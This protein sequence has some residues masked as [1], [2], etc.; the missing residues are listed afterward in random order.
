MG[1]ESEIVTLIKNS[2]FF[3]AG[4]DFLAIEK[5]AALKSISIWDINWRIRFCHALQTINKTIVIENVEQLLNTPFEKFMS[6]RNC[7][8]TTIIEAR[9]TI[10]NFLLSI[11][12]NTEHENY[13]VVLK[14]MNERR[15]FV[16]SY[17]LSE[18][19]NVSLDSLKKY[20]NISLQ[21]F[22][23]P[24]RF[25]NYI[26]RKRKASSFSDLLSLDPEVLI[27]EK[28]MGR[29]TIGEV[30]KIIDKKIER[31][32]KGV[33]QLEEKSVLVIVNQELSKISERELAIVKMRW[34][35]ENEISMEEIGSRFQLTRE[36]IRQIIQ[37]IADK[38]W[39]RLEGR[40]EYYRKTFL[41]YLVNQPAPITKQIFYD[42]SHDLLY[43]PR[44]YLGLLAEI[45]QEVPFQDFMP[46]AFYQLVSREIAKESSW[47]YVY[48]L[49]E[50][51]KIGRDKISTQKLKEILDA[52]KLSNFQQLLCFKI[53]F[54]LKKYFFLQEG[55]KYY[56]LRKGG[57]R[58]MTYM[59]LKNSEVPLSIEE[60]MALVHKYYYEGSKYDSL[61][62]VI[63]SIKQDERIIQ[64]DKYIFGVKNHFSYPTKEWKNICETVKDFLRKKT[65]QCYVTE[66]LENIGNKYPRLRSKYE[67]VCILRDD[68]EIK[69]LGFFNFTLTSYGQ[70][71]RI[72]VSDIIKDIFKKDPCV[73]HVFD[74]R[75]RLKENRFVHDQG[76]TSL[77]KSQK[78]LKSYL[79]GFYGLR[80]LDLEND[81]KL[82][83]EERFLEY[84]INQHYF[85]TTDIKIVAEYFDSEELQQKAILT[86]TT[87]KVFQIY[88]L[89]NGI[90]CVI[91]NNW[92]VFK[93]VKCLLSNINEPVF[94]E[95]LEWILKDLGINDFKKDLYRIRND[96]SIMY[97]NNRY[98]FNETSHMAPELISL[99]D[100]CYDFICDSSKPY[101]L[102]DIFELIGSSESQIEYN[103]FVYALKDDE[104]FI[105]MDNN[106]VLIK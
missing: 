19:L 72:K 80:N 1:E 30:Y 42:N 85:P 40:Q 8:R 44:L 98:S 67:L 66:V 51:L 99:I 69:D 41:D 64:F 50:K 83:G 34:A 20:L 74:I 43:H 2:R 100:E 45:F 70:E 36:R 29:K 17:P 24:I 92:S 96:R 53:L 7:G 39:A 16:K 84:L 23:F 106:L 38:I 101:Y 94:E 87:S 35:G 4:N 71:E 3:I 62:S 60:I 54:G 58:D 78:Y 61:N 48:Q 68:P 97:T 10:I 26:S 46:L 13:E 77:L 31:L 6:I 79:G 49:L 90:K 12:V 33:E 27:K 63:G 65:R 103:Q 91:N 93:K 73:K 102:Q 76:M 55:D 47:K 56:L 32:E 57:I 81:M 89:E 88:P 11:K 21:E 37:R 5:N 14:E 82:A 95:Q 9:Q 25:N 18:R 86:I 75:G 104:R 105:V 15:E 59:I 22:E 28:N 52:Q